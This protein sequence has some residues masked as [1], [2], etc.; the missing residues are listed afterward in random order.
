MPTN[1]SIIAISVRSPYIVSIGGNSNAKS[2]LTLKIWSNGATEPAAPFITLSKSSVVGQHKYNISEY[3]K[4]Y[5]YHTA[6][7]MTN[8]S[9]N[10]LDMF[11]YVEIGSYSYN[12]ANTLLSQNVIT[13]RALYGY[14][15]YMDGVNF[16]Q[17]AIKL[18]KLNLI[19]QYQKFSSVYPIAELQIPTYIYLNRAG[20]QV[21]VSYKENVTGSITTVT[22]IASAVAVIRVPSVHPNYYVR[23]NKVSFI[24]GSTAMPQTYTFNPIEECKYTS[25]VCD[26]I[27]KLG[28]WERTFFLK[29]SKT[30]LDVKNETAQFYTQANYSL[31]GQRKDFN[32]NGKTKIAINTGWVEESYSYTIEEIMLS[33]KIR[34]DGLP[35]LCTTKTLEKQQ[36]IN[37]KQINYKL[38]FEYAFDVI[39][40]VV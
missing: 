1:L 23:G 14:T 36:K 5:I 8:T 15:E 27:N 2:V 32:I 12:S 28:V 34:I 4:E 25:V 26:F 39:N 10:V 13:Y 22:H 18:N 21:I 6:P 38:E 11:C 31:E 16:I 19:R 33:E 40:S 7:V 37:T 9:I 30:T 29:S 3:C 35:A 17:D 24:I 20:S